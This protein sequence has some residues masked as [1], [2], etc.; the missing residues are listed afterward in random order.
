MP[1][2]SAQE[3][4]ILP[5]DS[6]ALRDLVALIHP[7]VIVEFG[8]WE[9][10]SAITFLLEARS[11]G[12]TSEIVCVDTWL[13]SSEHW[14]GLFPEGTE[15][16]FERLKVRNGEPQVLETFWKTIKDYGFIDNT[17]I[18]RAST[19]H[20]APFLK[21]A[22][23]KPELV[24]V[25]ADHSFSAVLEDLNL[26]RSLIGEGGVVAGDDFGSSQ[27]RLAVG[28]SALRGRAVMT[29]MSQFVLLDSNQKDFKKSF[30]DRGWKVERFLL[31]RALAFPLSSLLMRG[32]RLA[33]NLLLLAQG[34]S[35]LK[36][37]LPG[38]NR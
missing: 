25:D 30:L 36:H 8:S 22:G 9:G 3:K 18:V 34:D 33:I 32:R 14:Q 2:Q 24:Y 11:R 17:S 26:A 15:W 4:D 31:L 12:L 13:G 37:R 10:R 19:G 20:A 23:I 21:K 27:V 38:R 28:W 35:R 29:S 7:N 5:R 6:N 16:A 1:A